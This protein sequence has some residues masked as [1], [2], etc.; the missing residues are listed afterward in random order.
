MSKNQNRAVAYARINLVAQADGT[1]LDTQTAEMARLAKETGH[2]IG[3]GDV[4]REIAS[5]ASLDRLQ[6]NK[7]RRMAAAGELDALFVYSLDRLSRD[8]VHLLTLMREFEAHGVVVH[9]VR[10]PSDPTSRGM[11]WC[12]WCS[13][14]VSNSGVPGSESTRFVARISRLEVVGCPPVCGFSPTVTTWIRRPRSG[15]LTK[16]RPKLR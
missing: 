1:S 12:G 15:W 4:L 7:L 11:S 9:I 2:L 3:P 6:L 8:L 5:G 16:W 14:F 13:G 10:G